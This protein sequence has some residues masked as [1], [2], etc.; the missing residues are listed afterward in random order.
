MTGADVHYDLEI[1]VQVSV[2]DNFLDNDAHTS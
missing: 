1:G 2:S